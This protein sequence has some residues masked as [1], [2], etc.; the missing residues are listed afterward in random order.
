MSGVEFIPP[1]KGAHQ[2]Y[3]PVHP[4]PTP[5]LMS[6]LPLV[7]PLCTSS[8]QVSITK[9]T[10]TGREEATNEGQEEMRKLMPCSGL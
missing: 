2:L 5:L 1:N 9:T 8:W 3:N 10:R 6:L 4:P 7:S